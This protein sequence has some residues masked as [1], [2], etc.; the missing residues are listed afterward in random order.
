MFAE[1][2][3]EKRKLKRK[4]MSQRRKERKKEYDQQQNNV[5]AAAAV[6]SPAID[7]L[8][9]AIQKDKKKIKRKKCIKVEKM[10]GN[11]LV[12]ICETSICQWIKGY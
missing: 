11:T 5:A 9:N 12:V 10:D 2:V 4:R 3:K 1:K 8:G 6:T 7:A